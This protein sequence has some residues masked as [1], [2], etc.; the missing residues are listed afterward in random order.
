[1][2]EQAVSPE[3]IIEIKTRLNVIEREIIRFDEQRKQAEKEWKAARD[4]LAELGLD[5]K[6]AMVDIA[7]EYKQLKTD[8]EDLEAILGIST[9]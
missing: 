4:K 3:H 2:V 9:P 7:V 1:M 8:L 6:T 5:P